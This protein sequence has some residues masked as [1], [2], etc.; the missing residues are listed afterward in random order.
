V[1]ANIGCGTIT[2]NYATDQRKYKTKIGNR[3]FVGS[4][5]Q[6]VAPVEIGDDAVV[7]SG[8]TVTENV[9]ARALAIA[10]SRQVNKEN[11]VEV[12]ADVPEPKE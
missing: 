3:V 11:Y 4:D 7:A 2:C 6:F 5:S 8:S 12:K 1:D 10:R 9:P